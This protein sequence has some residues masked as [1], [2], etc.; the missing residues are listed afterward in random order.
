MKEKERKEQELRTLAAKEEREEKTRR[1]NILEE[2][3]RERKRERRL[4]AKDAATGKKSKIT[5]DKDRDI[6]E[7]V[8]L[9][10]ASAGASRGGEVMYDQR[11]FNQ[12]KG[13]GSGFETDD[14]YNLEK[15]RKTDHFKPHKGFTDVGEKAGQRH[16]PVEFE[17]QVAEEA[18]LFGLDKF[19]TQL[20]GRKKPLDKVGSGGTMSA[21][22]VEDGVGGGLVLEF[23]TWGEI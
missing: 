16:G 20:G 10:M 23:E 11:L 9:G 2:R 17:K 13:M 22:G 21:S 7:K 18:D 8:A 14:Q 3:H 4:E 1:G 15:I 12:E 6:S 5:R 19:I